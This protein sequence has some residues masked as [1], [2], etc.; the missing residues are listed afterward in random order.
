MAHTLSLHSTAHYNWRDED[1][2][3]KYKNMTMKDSK[4]SNMVFKR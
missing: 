2:K 4:F 3:R 1:E